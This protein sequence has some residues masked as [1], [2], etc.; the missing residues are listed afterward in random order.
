[1]F[2]W[3]GTAYAEIGVKEYLEAGKSNK[4]IE[5][6]QKTTGKLQDDSIPW[7]SSFVNWVLVKS[8]VKATGSAWARSFMNWG[9]K[10]DSY[11]YGCVVVFSRGAPNSGKGHVGFAVGKKPGFV[12]VLG[13][14]QDDQVCEKW[15]PTWRLLG[16][17]W[18][19]EFNEIIKQ[20]NGV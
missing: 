17:R 19:N 12:K 4:R 6:Y 10:I 20:E 9:Y 7:C 2:K 11:K 3:I 15:Y 14:N 18:C 5:E 16:Y 13:G 8:S 1:M